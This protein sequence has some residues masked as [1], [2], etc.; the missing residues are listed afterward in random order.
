MRPRLTFLQLVIIIGSWLPLTLMVYDLFTG[1]L[2]ANPIQALE[3]RTGRVALTLLVF[4]LT[5]TPVH[6]LTGWQEPLKRRRALGLYAF[7]YAGVHVSIF[8]FVDYGLN[9]GLIL[10]ELTRRNFIILG[11][12]AFLI[13]LGMALTSNNASKMWLRRNWKDLHRLVYLAAPLIVLHYALSRKG[14]LLRLQGDVL[15]PA[16]YALA[17]VVLLTLRLAP[18]R[19]YFR[20]H[21]LRLSVQR[22]PQPDRPNPGKIKFDLK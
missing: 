13:L 1:H 18:I 6:T 7:M 11:T 15:R 22:R 19:I 10:S 21:P 12:L 16:L 5:C 4:S 2:G 3:Q 14:D 9:L 17:I 20:N 8:V